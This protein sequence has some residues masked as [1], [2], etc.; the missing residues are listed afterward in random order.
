M[1]T[2]TIEKLDIRVRVASLPLHLVEPHLHDLLRL[3]FFP[4]CCS[5]RERFCHS[6]ISADGVSIIASAEDLAPLLT[7]GALEIDPTEWTVCQVCEG[8]N[9]FESVGVV[10]RITGALAAASVPV[11]YLSTVSLDYVL[12][13]SERLDDATACLAAKSADA[14][15]DSA[16]AAASSAADDDSSGGGSEGVAPPRVCSASSFSAGEGSAPPPPHRHVLVAHRGDPCRLFRFHLDSV[17]RHTGALL[18]LL[19]L[20]LLS[21]PKHVIRSL[22]ETPEGELTVVCGDAEWFSA[23]CASNSSEGVQAADCDVWIPIR[24]GG[25]AT[26]LSEVGVIAIQARVLSEIGIPILYHST[27]AVDYTM[28]PV[29]HIDAALAAFERAYIAVQ[30]EACKQISSGP[31]V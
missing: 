21:D 27:F 30:D 31:G 13:P 23:Y 16:A 2:A 19:Y 20:P 9:G 15:A 18:R 11:L 1:S 14:A 24:V 26:P 8:M 4:S 7:S 28:V 10:E 6:C 25:G 3:H 5:S 29:E 12:I 17:A 22:T